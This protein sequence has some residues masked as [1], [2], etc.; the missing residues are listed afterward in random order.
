MC[1]ERIL[2]RWRRE[3][4]PRNRNTRYLPIYY[5]TRALATHIAT[6]PL[7]ERIWAVMANGAVD[8]FDRRK[9]GRQSHQGNSSRRESARRPSGTQRRGSHG[10][11]VSGAS[12]PAGAAARAGPRGIEGRSH[13]HAPDGGRAD[14]AQRPDRERWEMA[15]SERVAGSGSSAGV[16]LMR[17]EGRAR[18]F[19]HGGARHPR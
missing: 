5:G 16:Q 14:G 19:N 11:G 15:C 9:D 12:R 18:D 17:E 1:P 2:G 7:M 13:V 8:L 3:C 4:P 6:R 10:A